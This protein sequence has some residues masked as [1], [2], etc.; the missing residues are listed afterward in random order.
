MS[1]AKLPLVEQEQA[2]TILNLAAC[3]ERWGSDQ[4][5]KYRD[6]LLDQSLKIKPDQSLLIDMQAVQFFG[7]AFIEL[8]LQL[9]NNVKQKSG[10]SM[11]LCGA[12]NYCMDIITITRLDSIW[13][14]YADRAAALAQMQK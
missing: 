14:I 13:P 9:W 2:V 7:S 11:A 4:I 12:S 5:E 6:A 1:E 8:L 10:S 3:S